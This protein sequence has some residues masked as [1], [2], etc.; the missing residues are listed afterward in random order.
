MKPRFQHG[1]TLIELMIVVAIVGI[2]AAI[3]L[4]A[5]QDYTV[6]AKISEAMGRLDEAKTAVAEFFGTTGHFPANTTSAGFNSAGTGYVASVTC[7]AAGCNII[8]V[9]VA[10]SASV[11][12]MKPIAQITAGSDSIDLSAQS[13]ANGQVTWRCKPNVAAKLPD[14]YTPASCR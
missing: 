8:T 2:L 5:Y 1:F 7:P 13:T 9:K 12:P 3:A 4:P 11:A 10:N 6:R 14:K